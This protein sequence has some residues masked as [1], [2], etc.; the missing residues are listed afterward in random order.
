MRI[1]A[2]CFPLASVRWISHHD[3]TALNDR[4]STPFAYIVEVADIECDQPM[5]GNIHIIENQSQYSVNKADRSP[6]STALGQH[7]IQ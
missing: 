3:P 6:A 2:A 5:H 7:L 1:P 4:Y